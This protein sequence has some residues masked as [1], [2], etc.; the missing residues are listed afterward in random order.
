MAICA[1]AHAAPPLGSQVALDG[2]RINPAGECGPQ[3]MALGCRVPLPG[4]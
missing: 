2:E 1:V 4:I 3:Q